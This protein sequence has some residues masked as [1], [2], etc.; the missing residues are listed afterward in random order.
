MISDGARVVVSRTRARSLSR[1]TRSGKPKGKAAKRRWRPDATSSEEPRTTSSFHPCGS[2]GREGERGAARRK[3]RS[4]RIWTS[5]SSDTSESALPV[6]GSTRFSKRVRVQGNR[7]S[8]THD[9]PSR[10]TSSLSTGSRHRRA[11]LFTDPV[12]HGNSLFIRSSPQP[13]FAL[14]H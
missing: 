9:N 7:P 11:F 1:Y 2:R 12:R 5:T 8:S 14:I 10:R 3:R 13:R 6:T 4:G